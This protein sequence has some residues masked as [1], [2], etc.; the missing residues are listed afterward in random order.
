M[1]TSE[2]ATPLTGH[3]CFRDG[4]VPQD[5]EEQFDMDGLLTRILQSLSYFVFDTEG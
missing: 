1:E 5:D 2:Q 4:V 3:A